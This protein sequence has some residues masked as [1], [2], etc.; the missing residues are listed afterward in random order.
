MTLAAD[1]PEAKELW[2][3]TKKTGLTHDDDADRRRG[4]CTES[5]RPATCA[6]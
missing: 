5:T 1:K 6:A 3:G 4:T 2:R